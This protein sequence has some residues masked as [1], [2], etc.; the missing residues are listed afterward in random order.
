MY[1]INYIV[2]GFSKEGNSYYTKSLT[3]TIRKD[4]ETTPGIKIPAK[5]DQFNSTGIA[6][7]FVR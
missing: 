3:L 2:L 5:H 4:G 6:S 1:N 7:K